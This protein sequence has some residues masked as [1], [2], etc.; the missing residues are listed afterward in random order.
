MEFLGTL[1]IILIAT[2]LFGHL[3]S[4]V[5]IPAVI[6]QLFVG[7]ILGPALLNWVHANDF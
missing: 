3:A 2:S 1:V 4:R 7:I 5:G 6:G